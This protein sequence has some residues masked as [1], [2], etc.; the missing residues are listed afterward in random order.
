MYV[1]VTSERILKYHN[2]W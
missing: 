2:F 1:I